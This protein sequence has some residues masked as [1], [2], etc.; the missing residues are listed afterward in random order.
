MKIILNPDNDFVRE[1][2]R[3]IKANNGYCPCAIEKSKDTKC[4]C[5]DF[6]SQTVPGACHCGLYIKEEE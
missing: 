1:M 5:K 3:A 6:R 4:V 2:R